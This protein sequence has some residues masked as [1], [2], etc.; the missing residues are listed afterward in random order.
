MSH[1]MEPRTHLINGRITGYCCLRVPVCDL[2]R[3]TDFYCNLIGYVKANPGSEVECYVEPV[4][5]SGP[6][7]FLMKTTE[8]EFRHIHWKQGGRFFTAF[9]MLVDDLSAL[10]LRLLEAGAKVHTEPR[11]D[12]GGYLAMEFFDPDGHYLYAVDRRGRYFSL[13]AEIEDGLGRALSDS[14]RDRLQKA[15]VATE[16]RDD[17][18]V[19]Q[20][21]I[22]ELR[23]R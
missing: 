23:S 9:E 21:I 7:L 17:I 3:S 18:S 12:R 13:K 11:I 22:A 4:A 8:S 10:H 6:G 19:I 15:C 2:K 16:A 1:A 20:S 14:E 5:A